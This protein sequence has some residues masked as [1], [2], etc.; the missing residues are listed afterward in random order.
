MKKLQLGVDISGLRF[1]DEN[2]KNKSPIELMV[3]TIENVILTY[4]LQKQGLME[5]ERRIYYKVHDLF[6]KAVDQHFAD[7]I[8]TID[9]DDAY[10]EFISK[11][12]K[13]TKLM[14]T[15]LLQR[16]EKKIMEK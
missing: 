11:C 10:I 14:P 5:D 15:L 8:D 16:V 1:T 4:A 7:G 12:F 3:D 6:A 2:M 13:E 9:L